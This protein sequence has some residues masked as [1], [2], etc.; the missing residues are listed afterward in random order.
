MK[1]QTKLSLVLLSGLILVYLGSCWVQ[2]YCSMNALGRFSGD[3]LAG[4]AARQWQWVE[5]V[6]QAIHAPLVDA[7][8][9]GEMDKFEKIMASQRNV[10]GLQEVSLYN[11][12]GTV[13]YSSDSSR[14][15]QTLP[16]D[17]KEPLFA[18]G[19]LQKRRTDDSFEIY[20]PLRADKNCVSCHTDWKPDQ[21][22]GVMSLRFSAEALK[23]AEQSWVTF[24]R[25]FEKNNTVT[26]GLT[27]LAMVAILA[28][29]VGVVIHYQ[30]A[31]PLKRLAAELWN[32]AAQVNAAAGQ[33]SSSSEAVAEGA[34]EQAASL[35]ET[36][37]SLTELTA[38]TKSN[39]DHTRKATEIAHAT[40]S[41]ADKGAEHMAELA[42]YV[43]EAF[44]Q[45]GMFRQV[46]FHFLALWNQNLG[47]NQLFEHA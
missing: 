9:A 19:Q 33:V 16:P 37:A 32:E 38:T 1:L 41:A 4:E 10:P 8:G 13:A 3:S 11:P 7:M 36:S 20:Q 30:M 22:C 46:G 47:A 28:L 26:A 29:L 15:K 34:S 45:V 44:A 12:K 39:A 5:V 14:L 17:F 40:H 25:N 23:A 42:R 35:E 18:T 31:L 43:R 2:R 27:I 21:V 24:D 6:Q